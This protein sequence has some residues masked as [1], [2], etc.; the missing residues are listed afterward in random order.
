VKDNA[1]KSW[2]VAFLKRKEK[3]ESILLISPVVTASKKFQITPVIRE[4][5]TQTNNIVL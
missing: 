1:G 2:G 5:K 4:K 3:P